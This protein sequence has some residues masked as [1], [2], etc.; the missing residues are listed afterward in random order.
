M[1][2]NIHKAIVF[3]VPRLSLSQITKNVN[4]EYGNA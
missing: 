4:L 1:I 3:N 2:L